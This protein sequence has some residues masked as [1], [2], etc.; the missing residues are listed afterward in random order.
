MAPRTMGD[1]ILKRRYLWAAWIALVIVCVRAVFL[2]ISPPGW[3][4]PVELRMEVR[5]AETGKIKWKDDLF[6]QVFQ[7]T[8][9]GMN[10]EE[11]RRIPVLDTG[12]YEWVKIVLPSRKWEN[13]RLDGP[14]LPGLFSI[15]TV[16]LLSDEETLRWRG[17][18]LRE[19]LVPSVQIAEVGEGQGGGMIYRSSGGDPQF[20]FD[21]TFPDPQVWG[22]S[23]FVRLIL[24]LS[25]T[26]FSLLLLFWGVLF[27]LEVWREMRKPEGILCGMRGPVLAVGIVLLFVVY[28]SLGHQAERRPVPQHMAGHNLYYHL[29]EAFLHG[30]VHLLEE[31]VRPLLEM[32]NSF[33]PLGNQRLRLHDASFY[34]GKYFVYFGAAPVLSL[35]IPWQILTGTDLPDRWADAFLL[36]GSF[37][38]LFFLFLRGRDCVEE[39]Q[40]FLS[41]ILGFLM[42][43]LT[44]GFLFLLA[45]SV[46]YEV[47]LSSALFWTAVAVFLAFEGLRRG[48]PARLFVFAGLALGLAMASRHSFVVA[49]GVVVFLVFAGLLFSEEE[50]M[51][52]FQKFLAICIPAGFVGVLLLLHNYER[53]DDPLEFGHNYQIG[54]VDPQEADFL[55]PANAPY[56]LVINL[57]QPPSFTPNFPWVSLRD[58][59]ILDWTEP[60][61]SHIRVECGIGL[62]VANPYLILFP[63]LL[64]A[65][66]RNIRGFRP[67]WLVGVIVGI[68]AVNFWIIAFFSYSA[69]RYA[70]DYVPWMVF[71]FA[72]L[73]SLPGGL[74]GGGRMRK[75]LYLLLFVFLGWSIYLHFGLALGR[76]L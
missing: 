56:N 65:G 24:P 67:I 4:S 7:D 71:L 19:V 58:Q 35:Y 34:E 33:D 46:V 16:E 52:R 76:I 5:I 27:L 44:A 73:L 17:A 55:D 25:F 75:A 30:R 53:F 41:L 60:S 13:I 2:M 22:F 37:L 39:R 70:L 9:K 50:K 54:V 31:P 21:V 23:S 69:P 74:A 26:F 43:G 20:V 28:G 47:A 51:D 40:K 14:M 59:E 12:E 45:R 1:K 62:F 61:E 18:E 63:F 3:L 72:F 15:R 29:T 48:S 49:S 68:A 10:E 6:F 64:P 57:F 32:E 42:I 66:I 36:S 8:G 38:V 11:S